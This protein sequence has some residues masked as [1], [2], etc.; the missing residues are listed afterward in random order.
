MN[1]QEKNLKPDIL[2]VVNDFRFL[3]SHRLNLIKHLSENGLKISV[4]TNLVDCSLEEIKKIESSSINLVDFRDKR[5]SINIFSN[6]LS[7]FKLF[8]IIKNLKPRK[9]SLISP[10]PI[11]FG[12]IV[13]FFLK[14]EKVYCTISGMGYVFIDKSL[15]AYILQKIIIYLYKIIFY[16]KN[17]R[18]IF[19]NLD[20]KDL[21]IN[22]SIVKKNKIKVIQGNGI[23]TS[24]FLRKDEYPKKITFL[25]SSRLL[26]DKGINEYVTAAEKIGPERANF[27]VVGGIDPSNPK[28]LS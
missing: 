6:I 27:L 26:I 15:K 28:S 24:K 9:L 1:I 17:V 4:A 16:K 22:E 11:I 19:Q 23:N 8:Y 12:G 21:F 10:K 5:S 14:I 7:L 25:F 18:I 2:F 13:S 20:D 3:E